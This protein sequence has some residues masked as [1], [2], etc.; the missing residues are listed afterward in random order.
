[1]T[2]GDTEQDTVTEACLVTGIIMMIDHTRM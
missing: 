1:M 2:V